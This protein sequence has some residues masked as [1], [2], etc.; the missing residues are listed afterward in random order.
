[1]RFEASIDVSAPADEVFAVYADVERWPEWTP[2]VTRVERLD[3]G[4]LR[5]GSRARV[6]QPRLPVAV[7]R[8]TEME[9]GRWFT[10]VAQGPGVVTT[11]IHQ[12]APT[13]GGQRSRATAV[14]VQGGPVGPVLGLLT[15]RLTERYLDAEVHGLK[16][17]CEPR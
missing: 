1:M 16:A 9:P 13:D 11:G 17:R 4:P 15:K 12:V 6:R 3:D 2:T 5:V 10:W 8:V 7:W 14:L